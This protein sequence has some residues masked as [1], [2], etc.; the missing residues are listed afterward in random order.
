MMSAQTISY[1][2]YL[3]ED[4]DWLDQLLDRAPRLAT[5]GLIAMA[6]AM[7]LAWPPATNDGPLVQGGSSAQSFGAYP[8]RVTLPKVGGTV[9]L[10]HLA[11]LSATHPAIAAL[12]LLP[13]PEVEVATL[14]EVPVAIQPNVP[15][16]LVPAAQT[17]DFASA[18]ADFAASLP[19]SQRSDARAAAA[20]AAA[21]GLEPGAFL[22]LDYD[23]A[24][25]APSQPASGASGGSTSYNASDGSLT[26][27]KTLLVD[28]ESKGRAAIRIEE[29]A[30]LYIATAAVADALGP[31][32]QALPTRIATALETGSGFIPFHELRG[33]GV[34]VE[35][36]PVTDR[37]SLSMPS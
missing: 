4:R 25:L 18:F 33:A 8:L 28:G 13:E 15:E 36:D 29:G 14:A 21:E 34:A 9:S 22:N 11:Q 24:T 2:D 19:A 10:E 26:V 30:Q 6:W 16:P 17:R 20:I 5:L 31:R 1:D 3:V 32:A 7:T 23:L 27:T 37:V 12:D 35:Y